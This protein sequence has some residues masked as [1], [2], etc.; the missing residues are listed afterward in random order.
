[1]RLC[2]SQS[3]LMNTKNTKHTHHN[4]AWR[5]ALCQLPPALQHWMQHTGSFMQHLAFHAITGA[6]VQVLQEYYRSATLAETKQLALPL[7]ARVWVREVFISTTTGKTPGRW[8]VAQTL[9]PQKILT[10]EER[11]LKQLKKRALGSI[12]F[13]HQHMTRSPFEF[14]QLH[15]TTFFYQLA[16]AATLITA[17]ELW[18][19][20]SVFTLNNPE[21][22][23]EKKLLLTEIFLPDLLHVR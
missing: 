4:I 12:L 23:I 17:S 5:T 21:N 7:R 6:H 16:N 15:P 8:M 20:R 13:R 11:R 18:A 2:S 1:M 10:G 22:G 19:R 3:A 14:T 9:F